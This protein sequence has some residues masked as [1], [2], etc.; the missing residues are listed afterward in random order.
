MRN[1]GRGTAGQ[2][3][4]VEGQGSAHDPVGRS[5]NV[6]QDIAGGNPKYRVA[7]TA[8]DDITPVIAYRAVSAIMSL[9]VDLNGEAGTRT[10]KICNVAN[11]R[12]LTPKFHTA[13]APTQPLP[14]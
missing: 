14:E 5:I 6:L 10:A 2:G 8:Q 13:G 11:H 12:M 3:P 9:A 4:V 7:F 1:M